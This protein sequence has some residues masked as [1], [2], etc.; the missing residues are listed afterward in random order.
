MQGKEGS[1]T[2]TDQVSYFAFPFSFL[3]LFYI[4]NLDLKAAHCI[5][6][7]WSRQ[8]RPVNTRSGSTTQTDNSPLVPGMSWCRIHGYSKDSGKNRILLH[9]A[10]RDGLSSRGPPLTD[11]DCRNSETR[12]H[13]PGHFRKDYHGLGRRLL[14]LLSFLAWWLWRHRCIWW[15]DHCRFRTPPWFS[16]STSE[17]S[18]CPRARDKHT[19]GSSG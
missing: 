1:C 10:G 13:T 5:C 3:R 9:L 7:Q 6:V 2:Q 14:T 11:R 16:C 12:S 15:I 18:R 19:P 4:S 17:W 8:T